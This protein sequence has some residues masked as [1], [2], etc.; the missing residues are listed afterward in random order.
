VK[1][2]SF[3]R[4]ISTDY[5]KEFKQL[6]DLIAVSLNNGI[7]VLYQTLNNQ[8]TLR[9]NIKCTIKD[10]TLSVDS[11]GKPINTISILLNTS[12]KVEGSQ[13][14]LALNQVNSSVYVT[15][16]PFITGSQN[17]NSFIINNISGLQANQQYL[18]RVVVYQA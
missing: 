6:I 14:I 16:N 1:L 11:S 5:P 3:K 12:T 15:S 17:G 2:P 13:I 8:I 7:E 9:D 18:L 10:I 4:L